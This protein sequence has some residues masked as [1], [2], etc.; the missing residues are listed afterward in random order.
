MRIK[1]GDLTV[2]ALTLAFAALLYGLKYL[3]AA[4][5]ERLLR[6][7][8]NGRRVAEYSFNEQTSTEI[9]VE[10]PDGQATVAIEGGRVR[11]L[12]MPRHICP[13]GLCSSVGWVEQHGD[14]IVCL[15]NRLVLTITGGPVN[16]LID[17]LDGITK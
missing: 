13:R 10:M 6:V 15:P 11:V 5:G 2:I 1:K 4:A 14:A 7:E 9:A 3:P 12:P 17:S 8:L 16:E